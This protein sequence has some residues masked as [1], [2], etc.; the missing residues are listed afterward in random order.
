MKQEISDEKVQKI[1][2]AVTGNL[3]LVR[4]IPVATYRLQLNYLFT[5]SAAKSIVAYLDELGISDC[6]A[7]P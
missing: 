3:D 5:F 7:S 4:R 1:F 6:Y 2:D